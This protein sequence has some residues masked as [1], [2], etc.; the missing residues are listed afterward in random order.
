MTENLEDRLRSYYASAVAD[1]ELSD[2]TLDEL[3]AHNPQAHLELVSADKSEQHPRSRW[4][5][6]AACL[7]AVAGVGAA[8]V[9][10]QH[11][12]TSPESPTN[13]VPTDSA[14]SAPSGVVPG[15]CSAA[16]QSTS[17]TSTS[18]PAFVTDQPTKAGDAQL[19]PIFPSRFCAPEVSTV[20]GDAPIRRTVWAS[21][22]DCDRPTAA[23][24]LV[25]NGTPST[26]ESTDDPTLINSESFEIEGRKVRLERHRSPGLDRITSID[27]VEPGFTFIGWGLDSRAFYGLA[28]GYIRGYDVPSA[29]G[30]TLVYDGDGSANSSAVARATTTLNMFAETPNAEAKETLSFSTWHGE[31]VPSPLAAAWSIPN[32]YVTTVNN[33]PA[34]VSTYSNGTSFILWRGANTVEAFTSYSEVGRPMSL[35]ELAALE[36][37]SAGALFNKPSGG[38]LA[39]ATTAD[40][41]R[42]ILARQMTGDGRYRETGGGD[43]VVLVHLRA[44]QQ[45]LAAELRDR[46]GDL[47]NV[48]VGNFPYPMPSG[49]PIAIPNECTWSAPNGDDVVG[50]LRATPRVTGSIRSGQDGN[51]RVSITNTSSASVRFSGGTPYAAVLLKPGTDEVV[52]IYDSA[53]AGV[54]TDATLKPGGS[55]TVD[56]RIGTASCDPAMGYAVAPGTYDLVVVLPDIQIGGTGD[57]QKLRSARASVTVTA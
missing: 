4:L 7:V 37:T 29:K 40:E 18:L 5:L 21:C 36:Y 47:V 34:L 16:E 6:A 1:I 10:A 12:S 57:L 32:S 51:G 27:D 11:R 49:T 38:P 30:L 48:F 52:G 55:F 2:L 17:V 9:A 44:D 19:V 26:Q 39:D 14:T 13:T 41:V 20:S 23:V 45:A 56:M 24:A 3:I 35:D 50:G 33:L 15:G 43:T 31:P 46:Y 42:R 54:G 22:A 25:R 53:I 8:V 28:L